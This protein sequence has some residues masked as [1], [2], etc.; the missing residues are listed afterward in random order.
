[1]QNSNFTAAQ[2]ESATFI[3]SE[4]SLPSR[5]SDP[6]TNNVIQQEQFLPVL[7]SIQVIIVKH[8]ILFQYGQLDLEVR[9]A[10]G[11][12]ES[13]VRCRC[14]SGGLP[15][16]RG[17]DTSQS[18]LEATVAAQELQIPV[19][20]AGAPSQGMYS[21][22]GVLVKRDPK[23]NRETFYYCAQSAIQP[24]GSVNKSTKGF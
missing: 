24:F 11:T 3:P 17:G 13:T 16:G 20:L 1:M 21:T 7:N 5:G 23:D 8:T 4:Y 2:L 19:W 18:L 22:N 10:Q 14:L 9:P 12:I 15:G 6:F